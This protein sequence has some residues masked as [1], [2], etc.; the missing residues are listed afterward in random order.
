M[1]YTKPLHHWTFLFATFM[2]VHR[3]GGKSCCT[4]HTDAVRGLYTR[5]P[6]RMIHKLRG[7]RGGHALAPEPP[8]EAGGTVASEELPVGPPQEVPEDCPPQKPFAEPAEV[9]I[10]PDKQVVSAMVLDAAQVELL[11]LR[12]FAG[13]FD[14]GKPPSRCC[15]SGL[16]LGG[17]FRP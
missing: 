6:I 14:R 1:S 4:L 9:A 7:G 15:S 5:I 3:R 11:T 13:W 8:V 2:P 12:S 16:E 10:V 17:C